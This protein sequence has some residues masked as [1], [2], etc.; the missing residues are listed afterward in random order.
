MLDAKEVVD[1]L[2]D[3]QR[4]H[5]SRDARWESLRSARRGDLTDI[6][7]EMFSEEFPKPIIAN[8]I[9][10]VARDMAEMIAPL[11]AF[12]CASGTMQSDAARKFADKRT[13][14]VQNYIVTSKLERQM[15]EGADHF[16]TYACGVFYLEPDFECSMPRICMEDPIGGYADIDRWGRLRRYWK[17]LYAEAHEIASLYPEYMTQI[18]DARA[19]DT[20]YGGGNMVEIVRYCDKD[21]I[22]LVL[23]AKNPTMLVSIPNPLGEPP[24]VLARRPWLHREEFKGQ[25]D[26]AV[27][28]QIARDVLARLNLESVEKSVQAPLAMPN[29]VQEFAMG[30][31]AIIRTNSP[32]K[33]RR[34]GLE[35][36]QGAF[37]ESQVLMDELRIGTRYP[38]ARS[39]VSG[40]SIITGRGT[41]SLLGG[42]DSQV[43]AA[44]MA[45]R[46]ALTDVIRLCFKMDEKYWPNKVKQISGQANGTPYRFSYT[47]KTDINGAHDVDVEYGFAAG[48][49]PNRATVLLLQLRAE[50]VFSRDYLTRQ[51]PFG[52]NVQEETSKVDVEEIRE[53]IKQG[54][55]GFVQSIPA[56]AQQGM[57]PS[58]PVLKAAM[59]VKGIQ[60]GDSIEDVVMAA[61]APTPPPPTAAPPGG[62]GSPMGTPGGPGGPGGPPGVGGGLNPSGLMAGVPPGQAGSAPGGRPD[63]MT[64]LAGLSGGGNPQMSATTS[65]KRRF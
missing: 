65:R 27:W 18:E 44:Q 7:P 14:I 37:A 36:P 43:K 12:Q 26:D 63:I 16:G 19:K 30:P 55:A 10:T 60:K 17:R 58:G 47:P 52:I 25:F 6:A 39:G 42:F 22:A 24:V 56:L 38:E 11:P 20:P 28:I 54:I 51:L 23:I 8:F 35:L 40:A 9:D 1:K 21:Q 13:K 41:E 45:F 31:D 61:F 33:V 49:D 5:N 62:P 53:S 2:R 29:D 50:K 3:Q 46:D 15:L 48:M 4:R 64:M 34:V 32:E 57:D 59:I